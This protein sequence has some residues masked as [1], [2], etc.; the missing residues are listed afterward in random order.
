MLV[1]GWFVFLVGAFSLFV[2]LVGGLCWFVFLFFFRRRFQRFSLW[3]RF[4]GAGSVPAARVCAGWGKPPRL[5]REIILK[6]L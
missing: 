5:C 6:V 1:P 2:F 4:K 3:I